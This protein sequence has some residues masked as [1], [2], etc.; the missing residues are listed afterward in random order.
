MKRSFLSLT[1]ATSILAIITNARAFDDKTGYTMEE[2]ARNVR[3]AVVY[4]LTYDQ[5]DQAFMQGT[6]F[7][8][9]LPM[10]V[11]DE[12]KAG[13]QWKGFLI[14]RIV[15]NAHL[16]KGASAIRMVNSDGQDIPHQKL[17][18]YDEQAD[19]AIFEC[20]G[21]IRGNAPMPGGY[22]ERVT[23]IRNAKKQPVQKAKSIA[24]VE[25]Q[26]I[27]VMG[28][29]DGL[30]FTIS[31]GII[32]S[33]PH[34]VIQMTAAISH[35]SSGSPVVNNFGQVIGVAAASD[36]RGQSLNFAIPMDVVERVAREGKIAADWLW[37]LRCTLQSSNLQPYDR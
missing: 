3:P 34:G 12:A 19:I 22:L 11:V 5:Q 37:D 29:P 9:V 14:E 23:W 13:T 4:I 26:H 7:A 36:T 1:V 16:V 33:L 2:L 6:G 18:A 17:V 30:A 20:A 24:P 32:S 27:N 25:G 28:H 31:D 35:G 8:C 21:S 10:S 15:T